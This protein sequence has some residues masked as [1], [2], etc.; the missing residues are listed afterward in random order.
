ML[1]YA[2]TYQKIGYGSNKNK[3]Q[4]KNHLPNFSISECI[5]VGMN[6]TH[7][8]LYLLVYFPGASVALSSNINDEGSL[9]HACSSRLEIKS[10]VTLRHYASLQA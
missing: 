1:N 7:I 3:N 9:K 8:P 6:G 4:E 5:P 10:C 2:S